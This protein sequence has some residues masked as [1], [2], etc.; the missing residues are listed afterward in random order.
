MENYILYYYNL[1]IKNIIKTDNY[2]YFTND[3]DIFYFCQTTLEEEKLSQLNNLIINNPKYHTMI[4]NRFFKFLS[5]YEDKNY[6]L[7]RINTLLSNIVNFDEMMYQNNIFLNSSN[8]NWAKIWQDKVDYMETQM[9]ELGLGKD[10]L[11]RSFS[12]YVGL[13]ENAIAYYNYNQP[14]S[15]NVRLCHYRVYYSNLPINYYNPLMLIEDFDVR[16]YAEYIKSAFF[17]NEVLLNDVQKLVNNSKYNYNDMILFYARL[18]YPTYY[19]DLFEDFIADSLDEKRILTIIE[20]APKY[21]EF[22]V[23]VYYEIKKNYNIPEIKWLIKKE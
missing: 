8:I 6:I 18:L 14:K 15:N 23:D 13:A 1:K 16:D 11:N 19:F 9:G 12:Y 5:I 17:K 4:K 3:N 21:E 10:I 2:Y 7:L 20:L 22:L